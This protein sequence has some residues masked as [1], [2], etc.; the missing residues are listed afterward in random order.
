MSETSTIRI[1]VGTGDSGYTGDGGPASAAISE[2]FMCALSPADTSPIY[3]SG[4]KSAL[5]WW[6]MS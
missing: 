4:G 5:L 3:G 2:P 1:V 6:K